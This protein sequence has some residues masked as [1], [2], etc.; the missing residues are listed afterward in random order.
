MVT[1]NYNDCTNPD[2]DSETNDGMLQ[3]VSKKIDRNVKVAIAAPNGDVTELTGDLYSGVGGS[4]S[5]D[6]DQAVVLI[7]QDIPAGSTAYVLVKF[8]DNLKGFDTGDGV[9]DDMCDNSEVVE[10]YNF[11]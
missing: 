9:F 4:I 7:D 8:Q 10:S 5:A 3:F 2:G 1:E 11:V 6:I